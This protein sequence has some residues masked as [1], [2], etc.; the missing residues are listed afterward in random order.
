MAQSPA[1][2]RSQFQDLFSASQLPVLEELFT[3]ELETQ[4]KRREMLFDMKNTDR[5]IYQY[6]EVHDLDLFNQVDEGAE[7]DF[8]RAKPGANKTFSIKKYG[9]GFSISQ[10]MVDDGRFDHI[11]DLVKKLAKSARETQEIS[12][13][14]VLNNGF[15]SENTADGVTLFNTAHTLP[16]GLTWRNRLS[17]DADLSVSSLQT[18]LSDMEQEQVGDS[19]IIYDVKPTTLLVSPENKWNAM[20]IVRS[21][22]KADTADNNMNSIMTAGLQVMESP[23]LTD[24]DAWYLLAEPERTGLKVIVREG[25][26]TKA[27]GPDVGFATDSI[28]YKARYREEVGATHPY[29]VFGSPGA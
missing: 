3:S 2:L 7:F 12:A 14:D 21:E 10:E 9:L 26:Q 11:Q 16:S 13:M 19:G 17:T 1:Q 6:S 22:K 28:F 4:P 29:G 5:D 27:A 25:I 15:T 18:A 8:T 20:E 24:P 23:H